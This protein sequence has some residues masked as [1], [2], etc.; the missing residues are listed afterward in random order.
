[1]RFNIYVLNCCLSILDTNTFPLFLQEVNEKTQQVVLSSEFSKE[2]KDTHLRITDEFARM[3]GK[4]LFCKISFLIQILT[5]WTTQLCNSKESAAEIHNIF[6][7]NL[8]S[9][10]QFEGLD[11]S[12]RT[13]VT[14][15]VNSM[16][17]TNELKHFEKVWKQFK[18]FCH[19]RQFL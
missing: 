16:V 11:V 3:C 18:R 7:R 17:G 8:K 15:S 4:F 12:F 19:Q 5:R 1:M 6:E 9:I 2:V 14:F 10:K 13:G